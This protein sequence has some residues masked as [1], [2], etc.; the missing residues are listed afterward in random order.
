[1]AIMRE[2]EAIFYNFSMSWVANSTD[3]VWREAGALGQVLA[4]VEYAEKEK[5]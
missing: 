5:L 2:Y 1:M 3:Q 4:V